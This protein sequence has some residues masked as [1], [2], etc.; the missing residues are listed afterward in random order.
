MEIK[1]YSQVAYEAYAAHC[2]GKSIHGE[3]LPDWDGHAPEIQAHWEAAAEAVAST[4]T[5]L[6]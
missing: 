2:G 6:Y 1:T 4:A 5:P 3:D